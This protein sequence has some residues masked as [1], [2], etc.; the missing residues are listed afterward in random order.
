MQSFRPHQLILESIGSET[1][2]RRPRWRLSLERAPVSSR[3]CAFDL[4]ADQIHELIE[5]PGYQRLPGCLVE[6]HIDRSAAL[7]CWR[8]DR[9]QQVAFS[10]LTQFG[11]PQLRTTSAADDQ[12]GPKLCA[13]TYVVAF[14]GAADAQV[15]TIDGALAGRCK[16]SRL[17]LA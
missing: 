13:D 8:T 17:P 11:A 9:S 15:V 14:A 7:A 16:R 6:E 1:P 10:R 3:G 4:T 5:F 2:P 12:A